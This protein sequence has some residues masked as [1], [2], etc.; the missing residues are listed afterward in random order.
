MAEKAAAAGAVTVAVARATHLTTNN[1]GADPR[2]AHSHITCTESLSQ[3]LCSAHLRHTSIV[4]SA[5]PGVSRRQCQGAAR[6]RGAMVGSYDT[7][8]RHS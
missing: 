1:A 5:E 3:A 7:D 2:P 6:P 8:K 4:I